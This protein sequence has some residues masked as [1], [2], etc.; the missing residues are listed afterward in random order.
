MPTYILQCGFFWFVCFP[1]M[2]YLAGERQKFLGVCSERLQ[3]DVGTGEGAACFQGMV[4]EMSTLR[5]KKTT[6]ELSC[7]RHLSVFA[8]RGRH[9]LP[10]A[11]Q[12]HLK[13]RT[14]L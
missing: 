11:G 13:L 3:Q 14:V 5:Q 2:G 7:S 10:V 9:E 1:N 4:E 6:A 12:G 8:P